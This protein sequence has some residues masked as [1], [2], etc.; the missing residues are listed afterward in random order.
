MNRRNEI[1]TSFDTVMGM[2]HRQQVQSTF[3]QLI[4]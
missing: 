2:I 3:R 4:T 1:L